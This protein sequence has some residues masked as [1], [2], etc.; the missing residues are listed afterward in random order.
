MDTHAFIS[1]IRPAHILAGMS[2]LV[3]G[4]TAL[5]ARKGAAAHRRSGIFFVYAMVA[6]SLS[7]V[8]MDAIKTSRISV[9]VIAGLLTFY[10]VTTGLLT[11]RS[12]QQRPAWIDRGATALVAAVS[13]FAFATA[14]DLT[15]RG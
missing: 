1:T 7:A 12:R 9:N 3:F 4:Y 5:Y 10:F 6:M 11:V 2:A 15:R 8:V 14:F 13:V